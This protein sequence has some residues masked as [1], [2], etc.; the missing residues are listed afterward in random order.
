VETIKVSKLQAAKRQLRAAI[1]MWFHEA[2]PVCVHT[3]ACAGYQIIHELNAKNKG[4]KLLF[5]A[6]FIKK[7]HWPEA[8]RLFKHPFD[9]F[10]HAGVKKEASI[11]FNP[12]LT[13]G[14]FLFGLRGLH[15]MG[16][17][18]HDVDAIFR[19]WIT[20]H[21]PQWLEA[22]VREVLIHFVPVE[23][24]KEVRSWSKPQFFE[25]FMKA[26]KDARR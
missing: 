12:S 1:T 4:P 8:N 26:R 20:V 9:F 7:E 18:E 10:K 24:W 21:K 25:A 17:D 3:L 5:D 16:V 22:N 13:V 6:D 2:D 23:N 19:T 11:D 15:Q 14:F